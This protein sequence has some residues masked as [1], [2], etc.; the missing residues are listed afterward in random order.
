MEFRRSF[1]LYNEYRL[2]PPVDELFVVEDFASVWWLHQ[3]G[4]RQVVG[5][6]SH[7]CSLEQI[8]LIASVVG[9]LGRVWILTN[10]TGEQ[11]AHSMLSELSARRFVRWVRL[12]GKKSLVE[13]SPE[14]LKAR[15]SE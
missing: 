3:C 5:V 6:M 2:R 12:A 8:E 7:E 9:P 10:Q 1:F 15:F 14:D 13:M 11:L 4:F